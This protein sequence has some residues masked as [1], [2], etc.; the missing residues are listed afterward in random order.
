M[1]L[2]CAHRILGRA[3]FGPLDLEADNPNLVG[4]DQICGSHHLAQNFIFRP[5]VGAADGTTPLK[6]LH[7]T[8]AAVWPGAGVGAGAGYLLAR[9]LAGQ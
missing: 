3:V 4:G 5:A 1:R 6:N 7:L 2:A 8:G 9:Q